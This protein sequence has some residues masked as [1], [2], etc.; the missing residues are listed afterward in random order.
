V[1][2]ASAKEHKSV[3]EIVL[4]EG[5]LPEDEVDDALDVRAMT[6]PGLPD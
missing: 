6:E 5:L 4:R 1:A 2:K 3:R